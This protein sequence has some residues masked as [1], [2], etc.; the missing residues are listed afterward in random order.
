MRL[1]WRPVVWTLL[2]LL[3]LL[4]VFSPLAVITVAF[5][6]LPIVI[7]FVQLSL[8]KFIGFYAAGL[9]VL[10]ALF[11]W[12]GVVAGILSLF[13]LPTSIV[14]GLLYKRASSARR[15][16]ISGTLTM[17]AELLLTLLIA[18]LFGFNVI[19]EMKQF[20]AESLAALPE[21]MKSYLTADAQ[22]QII[23]LITQLLPLYFICF[24]GFCVAVTHTLGRRILNK[25][26]ARIPGLRPVREWMLPKSLVWYFLIA[27][28][29][30]FFISSQTDDNI[31]TMIL[32][33]IIP[34]L[35][36]AFSI[37]AIAFLFYVAHVKRWNLALPI[38]GII[39]VIVFP[40]VQYIFSVL[41]VLDVAFSI[42]QRMTKNK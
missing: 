41:G 16:L 8:P 37:Q 19:T 12:F 22:D 31:V 32:R 33:N 5:I 20:M 10:I 15:V 29:L 1:P 24:S 9:L 11:Q 40:F 30:D 3:L 25:A 18:T 34:L 35:T 6:M 36:L 42:R 23:R 13:F 14:M 38:A 7:L 26:G 4:S 17:L 27:L 21:S 2:H 39:A 28:V